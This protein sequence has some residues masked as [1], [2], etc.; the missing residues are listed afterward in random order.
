MRRFTWFASVAAL[1]LASS[2]TTGGATSAAPTASVPA[3]PGDLE[4]LDGWVYFRAETPETGIEL[5]RSDGSTVE[6]VADIV[7][8]AF[9][10]DA[11]VTLLLLLGETR[12]LSASASNGALA[13]FVSTA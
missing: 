8:L 1:A 12:V 5:F 10:R 3:N 13:R 7:L 2:V 4:A 11:L 9:G 6:L